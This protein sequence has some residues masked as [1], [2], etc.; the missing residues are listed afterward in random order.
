MKKLKLLFIIITCFGLIMGCSKDETLVNDP[1]EMNLKNASTAPTFVVEPNGVDDTENL[2]N[3]FADA[4]AA[5]PGSIVKLVEGEYH[6]NLI[7]VFEFHGLLKGAGKGKTIITTVADL[8]VDDLISQDLKP[9]LL[10]FI[11]GNVCVRDLTI[12]TPHKPLSSGSIDWIHGQLAFCSI[13]AQYV[14]ENEYVNAMV[15]NVEFIS[16]GW[17]LNGLLAESGFFEPDPE[18]VPRADIDI[19]ISGCSFSG[20][21]WWG[22][23]VLLQEIRAGNVIVGSQ[24]STNVFDNCDLGIWHNVSLNTVVYGNEFT[25]QGRWFPLQIVNGTY[26]TQ[27]HMEQVFQSVCNVEKNTFNV[28]SSTGAVLINDNRRTQYENEL[29]MWVQVKNNKIHTEGSMKTAIAC[30]N[31]S[32]AVIRNNKFTGEAEFGLRIF[33]QVAE[34]YSDNGLILGNN[35]SNSEYSVTTVLLGRGT[36]NWSVVGGDLGESIIDEGENNLISGFNNT[37]SDIPFGQ[38]ISDNLQ[39]IKG[40]MDNFKND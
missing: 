13:T 18:S 32:G 12:H 11:G 26:F 39:E 25:G 35:F 7:E 5:E 40:P 2:K 27:I 4:M 34:I 14:A 16:E 24:G 38:T 3:A 6:I 1:G 31:A 10:C 23:G 20:P 30:L 36:R 29:P 9:N 28:S 21:Y 8:N 37:T 33:P 15:D 22:Y 19:S 17:V